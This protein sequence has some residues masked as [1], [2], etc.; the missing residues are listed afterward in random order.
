MRILIAGGGT[1]GHVFPALAL[2]E[3]F[4][5]KAPDHEILFVGGGKGLEASLVPRAG[6]ALRTIEVASLKGKSLA[7]KIRGLLGLPRSILQSRKLIR[8]FRPDLV[9]GMGGYA[10]GPVVLTAW[11]MNCRTAV[12]E[13]NAFPGLSNRILARFVDRIFLSFEASAPHFPPGRT[14]LTGNPVRRKLQP[15]DGGIRA[16]GEGGFTLFVFGGSQG[17]HRLNQAMMEALPGWGEM[18]ER[19]RIIHQTGPSDLEAV[20]RAYRREGFRAEVHPFIDRMEEAYGAA[21]LVLC[22]AGATT[23]FELMAMGKPA[24]L[25][26]YPFAA[27]DH[28]RRNALA[29]VEAGAALLLENGALTGER[30]SRTVNALSAD[31][32]RLREMGRRAA[33]LAQPRAA[34]RIVEM[35]CRMVS[36]E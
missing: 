36:G 7:G 22:R 15:K 24:L 25:V 28:Q 26:P 6:Y 2:A 1:G 21:D 23:L 11:A 19:L 3:A 4:R 20:R 9:L 35:C 10:S 5:A 29:M 14:V 34:E 17:A 32:E 33:A 27:N 30:L 8:S 12:H 13:Q 16:P 18:K 31:P